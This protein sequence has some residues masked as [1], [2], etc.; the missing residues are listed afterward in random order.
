MRGGGKAPAH[1]VFWGEVVWSW[2]GAFM[3]IALVGWLSSSSALSMHDQLF[4]IGSFGATAVL[5]YGAPAVP[6]AQPRSVVGG[7]FVSAVVGVTV[8]L[9]MPEPLWL[10]AAI[11]VATAVLFMQ[12]TRTTHPPGGATALIAVIGSEQVHSLGYWYVLNP[13]MAGILIMLAVALLMN[14]LLPTR[15][16]PNYWN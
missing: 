10:A 11:A 2:L 4:L 3:G 7:H 6:F 16:Y 9:I 8:A 1:T 12:L 13:V 14:N 5:L 15:R